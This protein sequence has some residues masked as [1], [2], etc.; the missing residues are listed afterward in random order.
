LLKSSSLT[1]NFSR[2]FYNA[3]AVVIVVVDVVFVVIV[4][5][6]AVEL[7]AL[8]VFDIKIRVLKP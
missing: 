8:V 2:C 6:A 4:V 3:A 5:A 1:D 7:Y